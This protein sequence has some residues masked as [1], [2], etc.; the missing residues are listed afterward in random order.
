MR[1][2]ETRYTRGRRAAL[3]HESTSVFEQKRALRLDDPAQRLA[4]IVVS[5]R[6]FRCVAHQGYTDYNESCLTN[7]KT[8]LSSPDWPTAVSPLA[9]PIVQ[10]YK[11]VRFFR[12]FI[13]DQAN[14]QARQCQRKAQAVT[15]TFHTLPGSAV[16]SFIRAEMCCC[17]IG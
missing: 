14:T 4:C 8:L 17:P 16:V 13:F 7:F 6:A 12:F 3:L 1:A 10:L 15:T 2:K 5:V 11:Y 9:L